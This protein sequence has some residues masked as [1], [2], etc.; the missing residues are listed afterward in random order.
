MP[1]MTLTSKEIASNEVRVPVPKRGT[2]LRVMRYGKDQSVVLHPDDYGRLAELDD[3]VARASRLK[4]FRFTEAG[5]KAHFEEDR[6]AGEPI[7]DP[8]ILH[9]LFG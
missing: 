1:E 2:A 4:P 9:R 5:R 7:E 3:L 6:S 8:E